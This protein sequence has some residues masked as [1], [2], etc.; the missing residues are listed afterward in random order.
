MAD[1]RVERKLAAI[2]AADV[3]GYSRLIGEDDAGTR[4]R[5]NAHLHELIEPA[6]ASRRG[7]IVKTT[8][9]ALLV[10]FASVVA[11]VQCAI[12]VQ[13]AMADRNAVRPEDRV[14]KFP[15]GVII[16]NVVAK[17]DDPQGDG[18]NV[19]ARLEGLGLDQYVQVF[20]EGVER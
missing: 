6:I 7:R 16:G 18:V 20:A 4:A 5:F 2:L 14:I 11:T 12:E 13:R 15:V 19:A 8:G 9:D 1:E 3:A 17:G 10:E